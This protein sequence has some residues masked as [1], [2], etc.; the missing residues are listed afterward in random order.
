MLAAKLPQLEPGCWL[1][2]TMAV[3]GPTQYTGRLVFTA[4]WPNA[5]LYCV[6]T[7][8]TIAAEP[9]LTTQPVTGWSNRLDGMSVAGGTRLD[10]PRAVVVVVG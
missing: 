4:T 8:A 2:G 6:T 9:G 3:P 7:V 10:W 5:V 1:T